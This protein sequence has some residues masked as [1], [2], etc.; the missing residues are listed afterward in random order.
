MKG[1]G[2]GVDTV[3][4]GIKESVCKGNFVRNME[5]RVDPKMKSL[6]GLIVFVDLN[7]SRNILYAYQHVYTIPNIYIYMKEETGTFLRQSVRPL[8]VIVVKCSTL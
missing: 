2:V 8:H 3:E 5:I 6:L 1:D 4:G 7:I